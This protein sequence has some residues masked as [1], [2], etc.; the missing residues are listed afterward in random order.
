MFRCKILRAQHLFLYLKLPSNV[1]QSVAAIGAQLIRRNFSTTS[2][3]NPQSTIAPNTKVTFPRIDSSVTSSIPPVSP[4]DLYFDSTS[5]S[6]RR[7]SEKKAK[8]ARQQHGQPIS[9]LDSSNT[10]PRVPQLRLRE[11]GNGQVNNFTVWLV[12]LLYFYF[13]TTFYCIPTLYFVI[14]WTHRSITKPPNS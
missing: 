1:S 2:G 6:I 10:A 3:N 12:M 13:S 5:N 11:Y 7:A 9:S 4:S 14:W 8:A